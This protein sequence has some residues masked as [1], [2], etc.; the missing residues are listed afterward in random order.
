[1]ER[2]QFLGAVAA[3]CGGCALA[4][5]DGLEAEPFQDPFQASRPL[6]A[7][8]GG[9][10]PVPARW[11]KALPNGWVE[12]GVCPRGC[13]ISEGERGT[14]GTRENRKGQLYTLVH[15]RPC[16][17][18]LD[19]VEKK[20]F[21]HVLPGSLALSLAT[22]GCN[23]ECRCCQ[24]WEIA[25]ARPEQVRTMSLPPAEVVSLAKQKGAP[26]LACTYTEPVVFA[27][28]VVDIA[29]AGRK[30]GLRTVVISNGYVQEQ[31]LADMCREIAAYK[32]DLKG[33]DEGFFKRH[34]GGELKHVL[35]TL[36]RLR[37]GGTWTEIVYLVIPGQNDSE[38][39]A[40]SLARFVR[41]EVG[42]ETPVHFTRFHPSY[43][44]QNVPSTPIATL[45]RCRS[46]AITEGLRFVYLGNV[47]GHPGESTYCPAC[48]KPLIRRTGMA[49]LEN[50]M[51]GGACPDCHRTI[52]GLW[53]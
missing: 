9:L 20:P 22:P 24:N 27:E 16:A 7:E 11:N 47:P 21:F 46:A 19:P 34:T 18:G 29:Q 35:E 42:P 32:V 1:M 38:A 14:C 40:R 36:R 15:S 4:R 45:D 12:C 2:R 6:A 43:R 44:L 37:R 13:K 33:M 26:L 25:Q 51:K 23:L 30:A 5:P 28:Y 50:R 10:N 53:V 17:L 48:G 52:P 31:P 41:D 3:G 49:V 8:E 39:E